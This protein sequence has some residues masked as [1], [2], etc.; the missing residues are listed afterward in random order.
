MHTKKSY[1]YGWLMYLLPAFIVYTVFMAFPLA[2]SIRLSFF[3]GSPASGK[4]LFVGL[5][6]Y[7]ELFGD[8]DHARR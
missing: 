8:A 4:N 3:S 2:D 5:Q 7:K 1:Q 6:N